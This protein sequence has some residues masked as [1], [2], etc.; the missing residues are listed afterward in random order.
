LAFSIQS[1]SQAITSQVR[2]TLIALRERR[3][4]LASSIQSILQAIA[5]QVRDPPQFV[6]NQEQNGFRNFM[7]PVQSITVQCMCV[8]VAN[9]RVVSGK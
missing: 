8:S 5:S 3:D 9:V 6:E 1:T 4:L 7:H 2:N